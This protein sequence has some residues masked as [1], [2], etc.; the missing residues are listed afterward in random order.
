MRGDPALDLELS[1][2]GQRQ[3]RRGPAQRKRDA[4]DILADREKVLGQ[5]ALERL[6]SGQQYQSHVA[7]GDGLLS[8]EGGW[9]LY[10]HNVVKRAIDLAPLGAD[11]RLD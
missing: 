9:P 3:R 7:P 4:S 10:L 11:Y 2:I 1:L 6:E 8:P 5:P